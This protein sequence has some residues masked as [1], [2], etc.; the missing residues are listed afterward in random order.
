MKAHKAP[1]AAGGTTDA[2]MGRLAGFVRWWH[3][4]VAVCRQ[5]GQLTP[6][7]LRAPTARTVAALHI[8]RTGHSRVRVRR[9][10]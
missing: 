4:R 10:G 1:Y 7:R 2:P 8:K 3:Q 5:C 6:G 9:H